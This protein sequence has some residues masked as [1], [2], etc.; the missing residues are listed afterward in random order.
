MGGM[1]I[2]LALERFTVQ[3][4]ADG[5]SRH[6]IGQYQRSIRLL[7]AW[8]GNRNVEDIDHAD[9]ARF[10]TDPV[11]TTRADGKPKT[12]I[13]LN[14]TR[15]SLRVFF[16]WVHAAGYAPVNAAR[17]VRRARCSPPPPRGLSAEEQRRLLE[18]LD[19]APCWEG[20]RDRVLIRFLLGT[21]AR[22]GSAL[23]IDVGDIDLDAGEVL[24]RQTKGDRPA[25]VYLSPA[26]VDLVGTFIADLQGPVFCTRFR[27]GVPL[28]ARHARRRIREWFEKARVNGGATVHSLRHTMAQDLYNR[29]GDIALVQAALHHRSIQS[30]LVYAQVSGE[31]VRRAVAG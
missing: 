23:A 27:D 22:L 31:R 12:A 17:L 30:T 2:I 26:L 24:L 28:T 16:R 3:L 15:S 7:A 25:V 19:R 1:D 21:G 8:C 18:A 20:E 5:R 29:T 13:T 14:A 11:V 9:L 4:R 6:T 10:L